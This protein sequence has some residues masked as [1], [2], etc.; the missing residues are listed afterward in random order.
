MAIYN[1]GETV[2]IRGTLDISSGTLTAKSGQLP[3]SY[4]AEES[5]AELGVPLA[6][7]RVWDAPGS[8]L[9]ASATADDM[10]LSGGSYP[11]SSVTI[12][13]SDA[14]AA[15]GQTQYGRFFIPVENN[16]VLGETMTLRVQA[17]MNT[18][19]SDGTATVDLNVYVADADG[20][21]GSDICATAAQSCNSLTKAAKDF[22]I[23][24]TSLA[25]GDVLDCRLTMA[26]TDS[27]TAT[28]VVGE[29]SSIKL[30]RD[31]KG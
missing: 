26:I 19:I 14:K 20:D 22:T 9:P 3:R 2:T 25:H 1:S 16:F 24:T 4:L 7:V 18:T 6:E 13:T 21:F 31:I 12:K 30:L 5:L 29:I 28:A 11:T 8:S 15:S 10:G 27:A 23:T 17:G